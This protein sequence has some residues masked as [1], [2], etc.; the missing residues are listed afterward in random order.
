MET[1]KKCNFHSV[2]NLKYHLVL[3]TKYRRKVI[4]ETLY[5]Y[6]L[7]LTKKLCEKWDVELLE[8]NHDEDHIHL[9]LEIPPQV[10]ISKF[11]NNYK[12]VTSRLMRKDLKEYLDNFYWKDNFWNRSYMILSCGGAPIEVIKEYIKNQGKTK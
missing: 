2:Y 3:V 5:K 4:N 6:L 10:Q 1:T 9:M 12:T 7:E 8:I 11:V